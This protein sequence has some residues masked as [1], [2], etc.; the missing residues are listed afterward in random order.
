MGMPFTRCDPTRRLAVLTLMTLGAVLIDGARALVNPEQ[1]RAPPG[2]RARPA[3]CKLQ[4]RL[5]DLHVQAQLL[6]SNWIRNALLGSCYRFPVQ[7]SRREVVTVDSLM[8]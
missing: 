5:L 1:V 8:K 4:A 3:E 2:R 7:L 6:Q